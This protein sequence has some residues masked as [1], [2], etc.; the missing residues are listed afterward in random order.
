MTRFQRRRMFM[1]DLFI[2]VVSDDSNF[3]DYLCNYLLMDGHYVD[4]AKNPNIARQ[5]LRRM[6]Y[7]LVL[8][9][10]SG[11]NH[12]SDILTT[13]EVREISPNTEIVFLFNPNCKV[14]KQYLTSQEVRNCLLKPFLLEDLPS[15]LQ[16]VEK[17]NA[18]RKVLNGSLRHIYKPPKER[19]K[20]CRIPA[21]I[22]IKYTFV[23]PLGNLPSEENLSKLINMS[24]E[25]VM[26]RAD[27]RA[28][29]SEFVYL[30]ILLPTSTI[31]IN[32]EGE[33]RWER[34]NSSEPWRYVGVSFANLNQTNKKLIESFIVSRQG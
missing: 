13:E 32:I 22:P 11:Y 9:S 12:D 30:N 6:Q 28:K 21:D 17:E 20:H 34:F 5:M 27:F 14:E 4:C 33:I 7:D 29:L 10:V 18:K 23:S 26:F 16:K 3:R 24:R 8:L 31:P 19:R 15:V 1:G 25:G 2:L